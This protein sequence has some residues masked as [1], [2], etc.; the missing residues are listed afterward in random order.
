[1]SYDDHTD[2][3][4]ESIIRMMERQMDKL[5]YENRSLRNEIEEL[6]LE[7]LRMVDSQWEDE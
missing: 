4:Y 5:I 6:K 2:E 1:M 3:N 7:L